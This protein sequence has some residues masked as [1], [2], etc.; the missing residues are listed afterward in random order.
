M[1]ESESIRIMHRAADDGINFFDTANIYNAG[2]SER[3]VGKA[4]SDRRDSIIVATKGRVAIGQGPNEQGSSR[5]HIMRECERSL[6][7]LGTDYICLLYT[8]DAA[9]E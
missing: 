3:V 6:Q 2:E 1:D 9:D 8:S 4:I 7:R 5:V